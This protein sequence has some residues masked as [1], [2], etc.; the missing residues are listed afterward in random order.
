MRCNRSSPKHFDRGGFTLIELLVVIAIIAVLIALLLPAVQ[1]AREAARRTQ[2][3]NNLKQM[4]LAMHNHLDQYKFFPSGG[5]NWNWHVTYAN[6][7]P[8]PAPLQRCGW[9]FQIL[10]FMEQSQVWNGGNAPIGPATMPNINRSIYSIKTPVVAYFCPSR[11]SPQT[12]PVNADWYSNPASGQSFAHAFIDYAGSNLNNNGVIVQTSNTGTWLSSNSGP[13]TT[14]K[15]E[16]GTSNTLAIGEKRL[17]INFLG[18]FQ[19]DDNEGYT[20]GWDH[21][22]MRYTD[23]KPLPDLVASSGDGNQRFGSSHVGAFHALFADGG[24]RVISYNIDS[25]VFTR[26]GQR[27]DGQPVSY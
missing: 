11:R 5:E 19:S 15:V 21:D 17:N 27:N 9:A 18:Q 24:V 26:L 22:T 3:K 23:R 16:D 6:D 7:K 4:G 8:A 25:T 10:Q 14:A 1:Q 2:C 13:I 12:S 20:S